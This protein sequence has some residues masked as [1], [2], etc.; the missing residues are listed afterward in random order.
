[1]QDVIRIT[2][3]VHERAIHAAVTSMGCDRPMLVGHGH[4]AGDV[5]GILIHGDPTAME[6]DALERDLEAVVGMKVEVV[7]DADFLGAGYRAVM[8]SAVPLHGGDAA[9]AAPI[10]APKS[11]RPSIMVRMAE[12]FA[13]T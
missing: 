4:D 5:M 8:R 13:R 1:M 7:T 9:I 2:A 3:R 12:I 11:A 10:G 6:R